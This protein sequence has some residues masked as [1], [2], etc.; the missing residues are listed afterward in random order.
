MKP[1][2]TI[3][4]GGCYTTTLQSVSVEWSNVQKVN[5]SNNVQNYKNQQ[6]NYYKI[7]IRNNTIGTASVIVDNTLMVYWGNK[8]LKVL[9]VADGSNRGNMLRLDCEEELYNS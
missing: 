9:S 3:F 7:T 6:L 2:R 4:E 5:M 1:S 8:I